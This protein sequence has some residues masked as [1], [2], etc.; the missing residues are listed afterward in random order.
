MRRQGLCRYAVLSF[1]KYICY[2]YICASAT[3]RLDARA[4]EMDKALSF[5]SG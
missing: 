2:V 3:P 4:M 5:C 1:Y